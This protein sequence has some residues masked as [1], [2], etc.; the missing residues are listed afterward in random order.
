MKAIEKTDRDAI[1]L[2]FAVGLNKLLQKSDIKSWKKL[3][4]EAGMEPSHIQKI[5]AGK[6]DVALS[7]TISL[8]AAFKIS[9]PELAETY[10]QVT[11]KDIQEFIA[12]AEIQKKHKGKP[13]IPLPTKKISPVKS[14]R[15]KPT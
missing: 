14:K 6:V 3:A 10:V 7:T 2:R 9:Y 4:R 12:K 8:A 5:S 15:A 13:K 1:K 11:E